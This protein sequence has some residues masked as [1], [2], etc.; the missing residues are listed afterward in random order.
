MKWAPPKSEIVKVT[1][2]KSLE[3]SATI[4]PTYLECDRDIIPDGYEYLTGYASD[5]FPWVD[6]VF[7]NDVIKSGNGNTFICY[8]IQS[9]RGVTLDTV[10]NLFFIKTK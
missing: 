8:S 9:S 6:K 4:T 7:V 5:G 3:Y 2:T 10:F 1:Y